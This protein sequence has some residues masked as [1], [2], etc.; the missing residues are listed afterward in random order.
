[1]K[2]TPRKMV[3]VR[4]AF[5]VLYLFLIMLWWAHVTVTPDDRRM[6]VFRSGILMGLKGLIERG[7]QFWPSSMVGEIL[8]WRNAQKK[9]TKN[10]TSEVIKRIIPVFMMLITCWAWFPWWE[11]SRWTLFHQT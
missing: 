2:I 5:A 8:V 3:A 7:G 1:M 6:M 11:A 4:D 9:A 10:S